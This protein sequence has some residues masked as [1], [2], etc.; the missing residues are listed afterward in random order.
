MMTGMSSAANHRIHKVNWEKRIRRAVELREREPATSEVLNFLQ[1][2]LALQRRIYEEASVRATQV[3][4]PGPSF[5]Q[6]LDVAFAME[7]LPAVLQRVRDHGPAKLAVEAERVATAGASQQRHVLT[8][9]LQAAQLS[10]SEA[11][12]LFARVALQP[13][14]EFLSSQCSL[15]PEA[16]G[17]SCPVCCSKPQLAVLRPEGDGGKRHLACSFCLTEWEFRRVLCPLCGEVDHTKL[18]RYSPDDPIGVRVEACETCKYY[19]KSFDLTVDGLMVPEVDEIAT[20][21]LDVW[22][23]GQGYRKIQP[24]LMGF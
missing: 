20:I 10:L 23:A 21:A 2:V 24:N 12:S 4:Q 17:S 9:F 19:L 5:L 8:E 13:C 22:A 18:P 15:P 16:F 6:Q 3:P 11:E 1:H 7:W 14:A